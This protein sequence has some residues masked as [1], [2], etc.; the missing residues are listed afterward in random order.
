[1]NILIPTSFVAILAFSAVRVYPAAEM[2]ALSA[3]FLIVVDA[4]GPS[5]SC[6]SCQRWFVR[7]RVGRQ[8]LGQKTRTESRYS[9]DSPQGDFSYT[10]RD[11]Q[12]VYVD[13]RNDYVCRKCGHKWNTIDSRTGSPFT[14]STWGRGR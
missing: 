3:L 1:M 13:Y 4:I 14:K 9:I 12:A 10:H 11:I 5:S 2:S 6:P 8:F 7:R